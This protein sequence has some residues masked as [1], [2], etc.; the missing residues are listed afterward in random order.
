MGS[1]YEAYVLANHPFRE[2]EQIRFGEQIW[3][4]RDFF[5]LT[6]KIVAEMHQLRAVAGE[7]VILY[8]WNHP[9]QLAS[10]LACSRLGLVFSIIYA[11]LNRAERDHITSRY[12]PDIRVAVETNGEVLV[13]R[14]ASKS[15][16]KTL[17]QKSSRQVACCFQLLVPLLLGAWYFRT[18]NL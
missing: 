6:E 2:T 14:M 7:K 3:S 5:S 12:S 1:L 11:G 18:K 10:L 13:Q 17:H 4:G 16:K 9:A 15:K 8:G